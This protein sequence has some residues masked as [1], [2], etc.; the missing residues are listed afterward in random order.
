MRPRKLITEATLRQMHNEVRLGV[1]LTKVIRKY[2]IKLSRP[3]VRQL[4]DF[5]TGPTPVIRASLFPAWLKYDG[6]EAPIAAIYEGEFPYGAW[7]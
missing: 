7:K 3:T 2:K 4:L 5:Y 1:P 6:Q